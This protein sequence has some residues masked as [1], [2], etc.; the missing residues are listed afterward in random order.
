MKKRILITGCTGRIGE[1]LT[2]NLTSRGHEV[3]GIRFNSKCRVEHPLHSC[4][5]MDLLKN[6][7]KQILEEFRPHILIHSAWITS[8]PDFWNSPQNILWQESS[9]Q[10]IS[11]FVDY[12]G[13]YIVVLGSCAEYSWQNVDKL[14][15]SSSEI[16]LSIYGQSKL[17]LLD[18]LRSR[19]FNFLWSRTF[20]Q[21]GEWES[22]EKLIPSLIHTLLKGE[23]YLVKSRYD[24]RD[25][26]L[27]LDVAKVL[28]NLLDYEI[29]GVVN[30][31]TG[32][33]LAIQDVVELA[34]SIIAKP[35]LI[36]FEES[37]SP[38]SCVVSDTSK[39]DSL[40]G[41]FPWTD[42]EQALE[43]LILKSSKKYS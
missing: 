33:G 43:S 19:D 16:P 9:K 6:N 15:E 35:E 28:T 24:V 25:F 23:E 30:I 42:L 20:F 26:V 17:E 31:G 11:N 12:G 29:T 7:P 27:D 40:I 32:E 4:E 5:K 8:S 10:L 34:A 39:L 18:W 14:S 13:Y 22:T 38:S 41:S 3:F 2:T 21:Y 37:L 1:L 36:V